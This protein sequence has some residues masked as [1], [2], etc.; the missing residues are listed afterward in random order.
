MLV[1]KIIFDPIDET[2]IDKLAGGSRVNYLYDTM[3]QDTK[4]GSVP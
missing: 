1:W 4:K 3:K 2:C